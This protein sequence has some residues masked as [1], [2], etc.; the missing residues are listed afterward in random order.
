MLQEFLWDRLERDINGVILEKNGKILLQFRDTNDETKNPGLWGIFGGGIEEK[1]T[2]EQAIIRE[3]KEELGIKL[4]K[5]DLD[6]IVKTNFNGEKHYIFK[7]ILKTKLLN[8]K[9]SEGAKMKFFSRKEI[10]ELDK[11]VPGLKM[12]IRDFI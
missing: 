6:L 7:Y 2:P 1:E 11:L 4:N 9:L 8:I 5:N 3:I 12:L 10:L